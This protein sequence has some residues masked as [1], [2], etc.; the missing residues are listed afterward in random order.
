M[1]Y[2]LPVIVISELMGVPA[3]DRDRFKLWSDVIVSQTRTS[4][5]NEDH[6]ATNQEM[7]EY[8]LNLIEQRRSR[9]ATT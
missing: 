9:P 1:A 3:E 8:F 2:P 4:A 7:T 5:P 6:H